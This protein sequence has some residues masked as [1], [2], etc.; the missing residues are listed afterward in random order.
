[1]TWG[2][3]E[4]GQLGQ[5]DTETRYVPTIVAG[6]EEHNIVQIAVGKAHSL[7]L[8][9][10]GVVYSCGDNK[11]G[12]LGQGNKAKNALTP[13]KVRNVATKS[14]CSARSHIIVRSIPSNSNFSLQ[15]CFPYIRLTTK[16]SRL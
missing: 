1:M 11:M 16:E 15:P 12:Q 3:N 8:T 13:A 5:G 14:S 2:R 4:N 9:D 10:R 7:F 6:L